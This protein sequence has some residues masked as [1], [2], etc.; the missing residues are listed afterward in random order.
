MPP[1]SA[2]NP[3]MCRA[4]LEEFARRKWIDQRTHEVCRAR[5]P[6]IWKYTLEEIVNSEL[7]TLDFRVSALLNDNRTYYIDLWELS[8]PISVWRH[9]AKLRHLR[10][11]NMFRQIP[12][13]PDDDFFIRLFAVVDF[14]YESWIEETK[15]IP[16]DI[17][18]LFDVFFP[19]RGCSALNSKCVPLLIHISKLPWGLDFII[20]RY[21]SGIPISMWRKIIE[22]SGDSK[23][24]KFFHDKP[25][26]SLELEFFLDENG[27]LDQSYWE[28]FMQD[29]LVL[30]NSIK[31]VRTSTTLAHL[32]S[33]KKLFTVLRDFLKKDPEYGLNQQM[34]RLGL[35]KYGIFSQNVDIVL[36]GC[37]SIHT[38]AKELAV[39]LEPLLPILPGDKAGVRIMQGIYAHCKITPPIFGSV[40][41]NCTLGDLYQLQKAELERLYK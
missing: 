29:S 9:T 30:Y 8:V 27:W 3:W 20:K 7:L 2:V 41:K 33:Q 36:H 15:T 14:L 38:T 31:S 32:F 37:Y 35:G 22:A 4:Q 17:D 10:R 19:K 24:F 13:N 16:S 1:W 11:S 21:Y 34:L 28:M 12:E 39:S 23:T 18:D 40:P 5:L 26:P 6:M 25:I